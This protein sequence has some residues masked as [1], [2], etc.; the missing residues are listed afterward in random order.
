MDSFVLLAYAKLAASRTP[1]QRLLALS[2]LYFRFGRFMLLKQAADNHAAESST[3]SWKPWRWVRFD[4]ILKMRDIY[5]S[6]S[7]NPLTKFTSSSRSTEFEDILVWN[8]FQMA[9]KTIPISRRIVIS[10]VMKWYIPW[11]I[12][13]KVNGNWDNNTIRVSEFIV[14]QIL[15]LEQ[16]NK[17]KRTGLWESQSG[18]QVGKLTIWVRSFE[19]KII[20]EFARSISSTRIG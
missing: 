10:Y 19:T 3:S 17:S 11:W 9:T 8:I 6:S 12:L 14:E 1:L 18:I 5:I 13:R 4:L 7:L 16:R 20:T 2:E 15:A